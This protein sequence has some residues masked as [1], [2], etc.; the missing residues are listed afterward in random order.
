[1]VFKT[2]FRGVKIILTYSREFVKRGEEKIYKK[3]NWI[4]PSLG[5]FDTSRSRDF[6]GKNP[7]LWRV[8]LRVRPCFRSHEWFRLAAKNDS[9]ESGY[10]YASRQGR[11][12]VSSGFR[13]RGGFSSCN[14]KNDSGES[15]YR[16][17]PAFEAGDWGSTPILFPRPFT[18]FR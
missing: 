9:G 13:I 5:H 7:R 18:A 4:L 17:T 10:H 16:L 6:A 11:R 15:C 2:L 12:I 3:F 8:G 1:M 14:E